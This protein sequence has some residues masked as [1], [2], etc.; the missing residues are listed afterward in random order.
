MMISSAKFFETATVSDVE[1]WLMWISWITDSAM[2]YL[3][4]VLGELVLKSPYKII[5]I[6]NI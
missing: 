5:L 6:L 2:I 3:F 1:I 4:G